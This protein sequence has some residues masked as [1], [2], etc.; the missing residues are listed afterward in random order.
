MCN[1]RPLTVRLIKED[2]SSDEYSFPER[3][4]NS[5]YVAGEWVRLPKDL[6]DEEAKWV[7]T[8]IGKVVYAHTGG[9]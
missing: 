5:N 6:T 8:E 2:G 4:E 1:E 9:Y 3:V 7:F